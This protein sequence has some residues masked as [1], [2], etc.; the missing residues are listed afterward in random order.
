MKILWFLFFI[1]GWTILLK[2]WNLL[3][4]VQGQIPPPFPVDMLTFYTT[5]RHDKMPTALLEHRCFNPFLQFSFPLYNVVYFW[6]F[7]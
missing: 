6:T 7:K 2:H 3:L 1:F 5:V 4:H